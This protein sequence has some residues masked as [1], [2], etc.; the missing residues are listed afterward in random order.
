MAKAGMAHAAAPASVARA[1]SDTRRRAIRHVTSPDPMANT[2]AAP[3][4]RNA[5][6]PK[7]LYWRAMR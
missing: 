6:K 5:V 4:S 3:P 1:P 7:T 2:E